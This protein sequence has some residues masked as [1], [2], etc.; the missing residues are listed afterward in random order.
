VTRVRSASPRT[1]AWLAAAIGVVAALVFLVAVMSNSDYRR[2]GTNSA[3]VPIHLTVQP[4]VQTCQSGEFVPKGSG[5][6][7]PAIIGSPVS[8]RV[9]D[10]SRKLVA[11]ERAR[12]PASGL[13]RIPLSRTIPRDI[14]NGTVCLRNAGSAPLAVYG[15]YV[16]PNRPGA[17]NAPVVNGVGSS[18]IRLD[19]YT[20]RRESWWAQ[21]SRIADRFALVKAP[22]LGPWAFWAALAA[23]LGISVAAIVRAVREA[24][25]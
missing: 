19:W 10:A 20:P 1:L 24:S 23:L 11:T 22:F 25:P 14:E 13:T 15:D 9:Y 6:V 17:A 21:T 7:V 3:G 16:P 18:V 12:P 4:G 8:V 2:T 5:F